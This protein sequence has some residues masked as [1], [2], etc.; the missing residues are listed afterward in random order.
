MKD[1]DSLGIKMVVKMLSYFS[2]E[3]LYSKPEMASYTPDLDLG[4]T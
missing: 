3:K 1:C 2:A 4:N